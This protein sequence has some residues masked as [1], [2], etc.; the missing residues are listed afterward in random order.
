MARRVRHDHYHHR[1]GGD[2]QWILWLIAAA[3]AVLLLR[4]LF[5]IA[6]VAIGA[7]LIYKLW[8]VIMIALKVVW[9]VVKSLCRMISRPFSRNRS[10]PQGVLAAPV[11]SP[12]RAPQEPTGG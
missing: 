2:G 4:V 10:T 11:G 1:G 6:L 3:I 5:W 7:W 12:D 8:P 9:E